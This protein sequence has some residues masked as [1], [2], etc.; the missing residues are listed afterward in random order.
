[1]NQIRK[2]LTYANVMSSI[3]VFLVVGGGAAFAALGKNTVGTAQ[4]KRNAVKVGKLAPEAVK[5]GKL[6]KNAVPTNRLRDNAV[7]NEKIA[8]G[9]VTTDKLGDA[10]V[11]SGKLANDSVLTDKLAND[12]VTTDKIANS[13]VT[14]G[15]LSNDSVST[16]KIANSAVTRTKL[17]EGNFLP[18][19]YGFVKS[20]GEVNAAI[21][22][23]IPN[24]TH[25]A[26]GIYCFNLAFTPVHAQATGQSDGESNDIPSLNITLAGGG[27]S[28]CPAGNNLQVEMWDTGTDAHTNEEFFLVVW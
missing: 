24:A 14:N 13:A 15:K 1:L 10:S 21:S 20:N 28:G 9:A 3:A 7:S 11:T 2:R 22:P 25:P 26:T 6:A 16:D 27:L 19:A 17:A 12:A 5:A 23:G 4:L 8:N 18:R